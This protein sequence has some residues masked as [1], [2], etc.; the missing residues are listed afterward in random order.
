LEVSP[1]PPSQTTYKVMTIKSAGLASMYWCVNLERLIAA[2]KQ[3]HATHHNMTWCGFPWWLATLNLGWF[4]RNVRQ[5]GAAYSSSGRSLY[6]DVLEAPSQWLFPFMKSQQTAVSG[7]WQNT[8]IYTII[9]RRVCSSDQADISALLFYSNM[10]QM[11]RLYT[12]CMMSSGCV[13]CASR[14]L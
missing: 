9:V 3:D 11:G 10:G 4:V 2:S 12:R 6:D 13:E 1:L 14:H 7:I 8:Y 5:S